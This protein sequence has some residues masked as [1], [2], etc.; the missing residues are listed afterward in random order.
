MSHQPGRPFLERFAGI[1][2]VQFPRFS[3]AE[4]ALTVHGLAKLGFEPSEPLLEQMLRACEAVGPDRDWE[5]EDIGALVWSLAAMQR[6]GSNAGRALLESL[7]RRL[8]KIVNSLPPPATGQP[9][10]ENGSRSMRESRSRRD[11]SNSVRT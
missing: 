6:L 8:N 3:P 11:P 2:V 9:P 5:A 7:G 1:C 4:L 10:P